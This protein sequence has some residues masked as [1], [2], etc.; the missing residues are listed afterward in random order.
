MGV[1]NYPFELSLAV[2]RGP[3]AASKRVHAPNGFAMDLCEAMQFVFQTKRC[4]VFR[5]TRAGHNT[6]G[7]KS[8]VYKAFYREADAA[9]PVC[10]VIVSRTVLIA[11]RPYLEWIRVTRNERGKNIA[12]EIL[13]GLQAFIGPMIVNPVAHSGEKLIESLGDK[14]PRKVPCPFSD[15][16]VQKLLDDGYSQAEIDEAAKEVIASLGRAF[17]GVAPSERRVHKES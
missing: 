12:T 15:Q 14:L 4:D 2:H 7:M 9:Q 17:A 11:G 5:D 8:D 16:H 6:M 3:P 10:T 13:L 1:E